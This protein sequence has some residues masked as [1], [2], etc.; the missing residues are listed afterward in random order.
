MNTD[1][2]DQT[3]RKRREDNI[4]VLF[5]NT[6]RRDENDSNSRGSAVVDGVKYWIKGYTKVTSEGEKYVRIYFTK[7]KI[8][9]AEA[10]GAAHGAA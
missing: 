7:K 4:G 3:A 8:Q 10:D 6:K 5:K 2:T 1:A 9:D